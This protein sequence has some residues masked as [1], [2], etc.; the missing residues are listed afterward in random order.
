MADISQVEAALLKA[1]AAGDA[2][3][4]RILAG[5]VRRLRGATSPQPT[6][7]GDDIMQAGRQVGLTARYGLEGVGDALDFAATPIRYGL[8][9]LFNPPK[10]GQEALY[11]S[12]NDPIRGRTG[13]VVADMLGLPSPESRTER[14]IGSG[15]R[16]MA[17]VG[18]FGGAFNSAAKSVAEPL[19]KKLFEAMAS[20]PLQ[21]AS[22]AAVGGISGEAAKEG[23]AGFGG[24]FLASLLGGFGGAAAGSYAER[25]LNAASALKD[26]LMK[27]S[28]TDT[29]VKFRLNQILSDKGIDLSQ[30]PTQ[31]RADLIA[32][33]K[34]SYDTGNDLNPDAVRRFAD[35]SMVGATPLR[36]NLTLDPVQLTRE[37]NL[38]KY[39]ANSSSPEL[40]A[41]AQRENKNNA[42]LIEGL[43]NL[44]ANGQFADD[45]YAA[46]KAATGA[47]TARDARAKAVENYLYGKAKD[48]SGRAIEL[49]RDGFVLSAYQ[50][51]ADE[52]KGAF[53]PEQ[54]QG[55]LNQIRKGV[56][57]ID[58]QEYPIPF[59]VDVIDNLKTTLAAAS[60]SASD[61]NTKRAISIVRDALENTPVKA[62]GRAVGG[63][64]IADPAA[65]SV[66][67]NQADMI[68]QAALD[69]FDRARRFAR[70]RRNWQESAPG[71]EAALDG[72]TPDQFVKSFIVS[73][74]GRSGAENVAVLLKTIN[75]DPQAKQAVRESVLGH[76]KSKAL[77]KNEDDV[78]AFGKAFSDELKNIG[79][80]KL[81][82]LFTK[83]EVDQLKAM[84][85]V[86]RYEAVQPKGSAV[87]NSNT[88]ATALGFLD[89]LANSKAVNAL[90][91]GRAAIKE[92]LEYINA[93]IQSRQASPLSAIVQDMQ[94]KPERIPLSALLL[95]AMLNR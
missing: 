28:I 57:S 81:R 21:Q 23:G 84:A 79:D 70:T 87:N 90:P 41:L 92:P 7:I 55:L 20:Q 33:A 6:S 39:G 63:N 59:N 91:F 93:Q 4:A 40:Q 44:G 11:G 29:E 61:G 78:G 50:K 62:Q 37:K 85:R 88:T 30:I 58:G 82:M 22:G 89:T 94:R 34:R 27:P 64:Q 73:N 38:A 15:A 19:T 17:G 65:L 35:Y 74:S 18:A 1:D 67:Q 43:N 69:A 8:N 56:T 5:E 47:V 49:D 48:S 10:S 45:A 25:G 16:T 95:P 46:G 54:I 83:E 53:L 51:L 12:E 68:S 60:R 52:N 14:I 2:A 13:K 75:K 31:F 3:G 32:E 72:A 26:R 71:I 66:A 77:N 42:T 80:Y 36:G 9:T 86:S 24:Q 76:L